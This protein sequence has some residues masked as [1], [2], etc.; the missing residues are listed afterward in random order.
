ML[1]LIAEAKAQG[2]PEQ[3]ACAVLEIQPRSLQRWRQPAALPPAEKPPAPRPYNAL[4]Q[5]EAAQVVS[6]I[7][8]AVHAD[9]S[10]RELALS[11]E[12]QPETPVS[13][14]PVTV[15]RYQRALGCNGPRGRQTTRRVGPAPDTEWVQGPNELWDY[16]VTLL[17][18]PERRV[19]LYLYSLLDHYSRKAVAWLIHPTFCS[20]QLQTLWDQGL[21]REGLLDLPHDAWPE[22]L[23]DRGAQMRSLSTRAYFQRLGITQFFS[24]PRTPNDNPRIESHFATIKGHP[25]YPGYFADQAEAICYFTS[26]YTWYNEVHPLTT[27]RM[28]TPQQVH[29]GQTAVLLAARKARQAHALAQRRLAPQR[30]FT[31]EDLLAQPLPDASQLPLYSWAG[32]Q[33]AP[34]STRHLLR[35]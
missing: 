32:P 4:S 27:L 12:N 1:E 19:F 14:S 2:L 18:T 35:N 13:V 29:T 22:S 17:R 20:E 9:Q 7:R 5:A 10:C 25:V 34:L 8:S 23:S 26:F 31:L 33:L 3:R 6:A 28:L 21:I 24:R 11:L 16:D 30:P 15:W